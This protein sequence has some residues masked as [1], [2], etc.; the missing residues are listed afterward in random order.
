MDGE[1][2][3]LMDVDKQKKRGPRSMREVRENKARDKMF[4]RYMGKVQTGE[5]DSNNPEAE[6]FLERYESTFCQ[7]VRICTNC[8][9]NCGSPSRLPIKHFWVVG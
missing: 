1:S 4:Q 2:H 5:I 3:G 8:Q 6:E 7:K 9:E